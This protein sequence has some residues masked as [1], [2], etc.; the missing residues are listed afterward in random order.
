MT[1]IEID[2]PAGKKAEW[3]E[4]DGK[5]MLVLVDEKDNRPVTERIKTLDDACRELGSNHP[6]VVE[7]NNSRNW[8][9][10]ADTM[11][12]LALKI[13]VSALNEGWNQETERLDSEL[14]DTKQHNNG[15]FYY[16]FFNYYSNEE[17]E[18]VGVEQCGQF[19]KKV[20]NGWLG[21]YKSYCCTPSL[22]DG[23][24]MRLALRSEKLA[25]Y[26]GEQFI[27]IWAD[28]LLK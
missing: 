15:C 8:T 12:Y 27:D 10:S 14:T 21:L 7:F 19:V 1:K 23:L 25:E 20:T 6:L 3:Q 17:V 2:V 18:R 13:I 5:T 24:G 28:F 16:P 9:H 4:V 26:C 22:I 11:A